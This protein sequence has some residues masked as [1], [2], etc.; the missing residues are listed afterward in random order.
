MFITADVKTLAVWRAAGGERGV[1][2]IRA[3]AGGRCPGGKKRGPCDGR[4]P[5][6]RA[7]LPEADGV[8]G[9]EHRSD[10]RLDPPRGKA[11]GRVRHAGRQRPGAQGV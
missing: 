9:S 3:D 6:S 1:K 2:V 10:Q 11:A 7:G 5:L 4:S 8:A